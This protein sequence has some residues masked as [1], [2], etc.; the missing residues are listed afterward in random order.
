MQRKGRSRQG[1]ETSV[2]STRWE[3]R[4]K[5]SV[6]A[7]L[8]CKV[9][10]CGGEKVTHR[11]SSLG[12]RVQLKECPPA[13]HLMSFPVHQEAPNHFPSAV[14]QIIASKWQCVRANSP[15]AAPR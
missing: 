15:P 6:A 12:L 14:V 10:Y 2:G 5:Q 9:R 7:G 13:A 1:R 11:V 3:K 8:T 4:A